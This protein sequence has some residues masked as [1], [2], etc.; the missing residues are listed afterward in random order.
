M[1]KVYDHYM[2]MEELSNDAEYQ[3]Y[4]V[5][6]AMTEEDLDRMAEDQGAA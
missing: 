2:E 1:S 5:E 6:I 4:L 3:N